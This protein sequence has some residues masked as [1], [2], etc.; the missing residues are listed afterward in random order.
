MLL[1]TLRTTIINAI[2]AWHQMQWTVL[3]RDDDHFLRLMATIITH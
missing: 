2:N 1:A 3:T